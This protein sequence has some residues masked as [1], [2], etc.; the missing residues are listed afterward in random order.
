MDMAGRVWT[1][2]AARMKAK[3]EHRVP[4]CR[5]AVEVL[6]AAWELGDSSDL[7]F[8]M[9]SGKPVAASTLPKMPQQHGIAAVAHG[10]RSSFRDWA[11]EE[12]DHPRAAVY[13]QLGLNKWVPAVPLLGHVRTTPDSLH[14]LGFRNPGT[15]QGADGGRRLGQL[16]AG[17]A[18]SGRRR[19]HPTARTPA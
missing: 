9:R 12:T 18:H 3:R 15:C 7:V 10:F 4:L 11:A 19:P 14:A 13:T 17:P 8:P 2:S 6:E 16:H 1:I 5:R